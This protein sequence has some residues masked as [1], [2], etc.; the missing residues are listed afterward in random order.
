MIQLA[1][2][3]RRILVAG[4]L[5]TGSIGFFA[6]TWSEP[7]AD[8]L[9]LGSPRVLLIGG[10]AALANSVAYL[11]LLYLRGDIRLPAFDPDEPAISR[12]DASKE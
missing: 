2:R 6:I 4:M 12:E 7:I 5:L 10:L 8:A 1:E 11:L 9:N 3:R